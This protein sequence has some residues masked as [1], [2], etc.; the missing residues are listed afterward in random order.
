MS[1]EKTHPPKPSLFGRLLLSSRS[2]SLMLA[3]LKPHGWHVD[4]Q[5]DI[6]PS[7]PSFA[8]FITLPETNMAP[9]NYFPIGEAYF[10]GLC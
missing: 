3:S 4:T 9:K 6:R 2:L 1:P 8:R 10:Q 7:V 5:N